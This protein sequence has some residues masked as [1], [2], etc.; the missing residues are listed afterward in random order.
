MMTKQLTTQIN[1][2][3]KTTAQNTRKTFLSAIR[4]ALIAT[5][6]TI[7]S[8]FSLSDAS[9]A[10]AKKTV[11]KVAGAK[12]AAA[13]TFKKVAAK[14][15]AVK[16]DGEFKLLNAYKAAIAANPALDS[17]WNKTTEG[18]ASWYGGFFHG[19]KTAMGTTYNMYEMTCASRTLPLGTKL[20][21][22]NTDNDKSVFVT[23]TDRGPYVGG[24]ILDLS[25]QAAMDL[26][27]FDAGT[28]HVKYEILDGTEGDV[29][30]ANDQ[31]EGVVGRSENVAVDS[32]SVFQPII[33][34]L[35]GIPTSASS[36]L[37][38]VGAVF[39]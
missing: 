34:A 28:G 29:Y 35:A 18:L 13:K 7:S 3:S 27:Y 14:A 2:I 30:A 39:S 12:K 32:S 4:I 22:T 1:T 31:F 23:V 24:R 25:K 26:G 19:R 20:K 36:A 37:D 8:L 21:V 6:L 17:A 38:F 33:D 11:K 10:F 9:V 15:R 16:S 5:V